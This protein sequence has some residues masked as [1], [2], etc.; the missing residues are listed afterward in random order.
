MTDTASKRNQC[1]K[2]Q[3]LPR[4]L[5]MTFLAMAFWQSNC[6]DAAEVVTKLT[7]HQDL[8]TLVHVDLG[9]EGASQGDMLAF[10]AVVKTANGV[11]GKL[12]GFVLTVDIPEKDHEVFQDR[13]VSM[14]FDLGG[15]NTLVIAG[16]SV[17]PHRGELEVQKT[18]HKC[19]QSLAAPGNT[20]VREGKFQ[21]HATKM[22]ATPIALSLLTDSPVAP[23]GM[24]KNTLN[25]LPQP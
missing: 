8:P 4:H 13:I 23:A 25:Q 1:L 5:L 11:K 3:C 10:D 6:L 2:T 9:K 17:Y 24:F 20:V 19:V 14:V 7:I 21:R 16:K 18:I 15:A 22:V 12:S